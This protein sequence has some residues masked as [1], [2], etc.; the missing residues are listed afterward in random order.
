LKR[1]RI[2]LFPPWAEREREGHGRSRRGDDAAEHVVVGFEEDVGAVDGREHVAQAHLGLD[3]RRRRHD[4]G[5]L[6]DLLELEAELRAGAERDDAVEPADD[7]EELA[8]LGVDGVAAPERQA[9]EARAPGDVRE[10]GPRQAPRAAGEA[11]RFEQGPELAAGELV[12]RHGVL[13][14][15][16]RGGAAGDARRAEEAS[17]ALKCRRS[18]PAKPPPGPP[19]KSPPVM[20][21]ETEGGPRGSAGSFRG[22]SQITARACDDAARKRFSLQQRR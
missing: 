7:G 10:V 4:D 3:G 6:A 11:V 1:R 19:R 16:G 14:L 18:Q 21:L 8:R 20:R 17:P 15:H 13:D 9:L 22:V 2:T 5:P 12:E